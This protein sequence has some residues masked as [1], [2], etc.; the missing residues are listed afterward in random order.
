MQCKYWDANLKTTHQSRKSNRS[1]IYHCTKE[2]WC[3]EPWHKNS[4]WKKIEVV[5]LDKYSS[6]EVWLG[7]YFQI[8]RLWLD[9]SE[10]V[11]A[12]MLIYQPEVVASFQTDPLWLSDMWDCKFQKKRVV[13]N[14]W[15]R[16]LLFCSCD[17]IISSFLVV[18]SP[19]WLFS[20]SI[21]PL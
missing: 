16:I 5:M 11:R 12:S 13:I 21:S 2:H 15:C 17:V 6:L 18:S 19:K 10:G 1:W 3:R 20:I 7:T 4:P 9:Y 8:V 14:N